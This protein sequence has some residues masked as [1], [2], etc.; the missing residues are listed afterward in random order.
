MSDSQTPRPPRQRP[1]LAR[2]VWDR[3]YTWKEAGEVFQCTGEAVRLWCRP[4]DDDSRR[5]PEKATMELI[6]TVTGGEVTAADFYPAPEHVRV[7]EDVQ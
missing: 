4:F 3:G 2:W 6:A 1:A 7:R 5:T